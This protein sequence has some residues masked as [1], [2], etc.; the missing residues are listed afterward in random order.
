[1]SAAPVA[2]GPQSPAGCTP[3][4]HTGKPIIL[5]GGCCR[6]GGSRL[7]VCPLK[8]HNGP[9]PLPQSSATCPVAPEPTVTLSLAL[10]PVFSRPHLACCQGP[11]TAVSSGP[12]RASTTLGPSSSTVLDGLTVKLLTL[13]GKDGPWA[14]ALGSDLQ[15]ALK[16]MEAPDQRPLTFTPPMGVNPWGKG[17]NGE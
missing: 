3:F 4:P 16:T 9:E 5:S 13:S 2:S 14:G 6:R 10:A 15:G 17:N 11:R 1:M 12:D 8:G 7:A